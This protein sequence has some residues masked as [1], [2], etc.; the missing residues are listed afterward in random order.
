MLKT[1]IFQQIGLAAIPQHCERLQHD[2]VLSAIVQKVPLW[3]IRMGFD[4][5]NYPIN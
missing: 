2:P 1:R 4:V 5:N 3:E